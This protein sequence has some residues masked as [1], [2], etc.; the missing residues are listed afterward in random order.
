MK[1]LENIKFNP[2]IAGILVLVSAILLYQLAG[3]ALFIT[4][5]GLK[6]DSTNAGIVRIISSV[7]QIIFLLI[8]PIFAAKLFYNNF[9]DIFKIK[10]IP[11]AE[12]LIAIIGL[13]FLVVASQVFVFLQTNLLDYFSKL[14]S[15]FA[16]WIKVLK[17]A[18]KMLEQS[19][20][21]LIDAN[22][23]FELISVVISIAI[24]PSICEE[25]LFR[26]FV[27]SSFE[28]RLK[29]ILAVSLT[30]ILFGIIHLNFLGM[31]P[32]IAFGFYFSYIAY[33][34]ESIFVAVILHFLNN[35][36]TVT[37]FHFTRDNRILDP[38]PKTDLSDST[39]I[40]LFL[41]NIFLFILSMIIL[42]KVIKV[43]K[44][45]ILEN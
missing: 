13:I 36:V 32:L 30:A 8:L 14:N 41:T 3:A 40:F 21:T 10:K 26:G 31:F 12:T 22:S 29:P 6:I 45:K 16:Y 34:T 15:D 19:Y 4:I 24:V 44:T 18:D 11:I 17:E 5:V 23:I 42:N 2:T 28:Q 38:S 25:F 7:T 20:T 43:K 39:M 1:K 35:F 37:L 27:L 9:I 33:K